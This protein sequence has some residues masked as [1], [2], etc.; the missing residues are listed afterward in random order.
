MP[1]IGS[2]DRPSAA[3]LQAEVAPEVQVFK[4]MPRGA[5]AP[6]IITYGSLLTAASHAGDERSLREASPPPSQPNACSL[7]KLAVL[8]VDTA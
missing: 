7:L 6:N 5:T 4:G 8:W 3:P 2:Q 1:R